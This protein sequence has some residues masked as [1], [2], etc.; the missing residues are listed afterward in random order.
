MSHTRK[1][2]KRIIEKRLRHEIDIGEQQSGFLAGKGTTDIV[3]SL[4]QMLE[5][6]GENQKCESVLEKK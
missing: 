3:I 4:K 2:L 1:V 5:Q 6:C